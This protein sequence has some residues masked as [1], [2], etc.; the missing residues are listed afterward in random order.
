MSAFYPT[1]FGSGSSG[2]G[3]NTIVRNDSKKTLTNRRSVRTG[4]E[5]R[6]SFGSS[7]D[8]AGKEAQH[9]KRSAQRSAFWVLG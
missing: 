4:K 3:K 7:E 2:L 6:F 8:K 1:L 9:Q 5:I